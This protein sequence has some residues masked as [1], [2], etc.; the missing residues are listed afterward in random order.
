MERR[1]LWIIILIC[2]TALAAGTL[3]LLLNIREESVYDDVSV[4]LFFGSLSTS[5]TERL[6]TLSGEALEAGD[7]E[8]ALALVTYAYTRHDG[9]LTGAV[10]LQWCRV[11]LS[12]G[13]Y[14]DAVEVAGRL[15]REHPDSD[16]LTGDKLGPLLY[17]HALSTVG[18]EGFDYALA[19]ALRELA[20][21]ADSAAVDD[22]DA[23]LD[24]ELARVYEMEWV[25]EYRGEME[26]LN[27]ATARR[28]VGAA[29]HLAESRAPE[30]FAAEL[31]RLLNFGPPPGEE[32]PLVGEPRLVEYLILT[33]R[34]SVKIAGTDVEEV[35]PEE[36][37]EVEEVAVTTV[38]ED[39]DDEGDWLTR[40]LAE[41]MSDEEIALL[42]EVLS[43]VPIQEERATYRAV[44]TVECRLESFTPL[45][46]LLHLGLDPYTGRPTLR[47]P[48]APADPPDNDSE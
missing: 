10:M 45:E 12:Q 46:L 9:E 24:A 14:P 36:E 48:V 1:K 15:I 39:D 8:R 26:Y 16:V 19:V 17:A 18:D 42:R 43:Q 13:M 34:V 29:E 41:G 44:T 5:E 38:D 40:H 2:S 4:R 22:I 27:P 28:D 37:E 33:D 21:R 35:K 11:L 3:A 23:L 31:V 47:D 20:R 30:H 7:H 6:L 25:F 32:T